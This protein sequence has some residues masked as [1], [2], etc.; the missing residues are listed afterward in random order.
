MTAGFNQSVLIK[1]PLLL[2]LEVALDFWRFIVSARAADYPCRL[3]RRKRVDL[4]T[5]YHY[6]ADTL[7]LGAKPQQ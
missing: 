1:L 2:L 4:S 7:C 3:N 5:L 6:C